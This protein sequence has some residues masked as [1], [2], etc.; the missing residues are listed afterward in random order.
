MSNLNDM[1]TY[2]VETERGEAQG[3]I[4]RPGDTL[5]LRLPVSLNEYDDE[6]L[7]TIVT[8][9]RQTMG[10]AI[11]IVVLGHEMEV[12]KASHVPYREN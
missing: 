11:E 8:S 5:I 3:L 7:E 4:F 12:H 10:D 2:A 1:A 6:A 9:L